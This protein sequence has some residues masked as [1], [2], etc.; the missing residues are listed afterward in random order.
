MAWK[1][2]IEKLI[3]KICFFGHRGALACKALAFDTIRY[4]IF[5][6]NWVATRWE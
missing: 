3:N 1:L 6:W 2:E 5:N 4:D